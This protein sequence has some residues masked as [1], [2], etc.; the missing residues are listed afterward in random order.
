MS[1]KFELMMEWKIQKAME[2]EAQRKRREIEDKLLELLL[3]DET[4][5]GSINYLEDN[6]KATVTVRMN[7]KVDS[8]LVQE[9]AAENNLTSH[10]NYLFRWKPEIDSKAWKSAP[11]EITTPL[12]NAIETKPGRPSFKI[13]EM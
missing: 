2:G 13:V 12:L 8:D 9:I 11:K 3:V 4:Q 5:E 7:R 1:E 6:L 10:L